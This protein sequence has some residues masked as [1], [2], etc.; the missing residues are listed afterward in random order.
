[1]TTEE[2]YTLADME[3][4]EQID[5]DLMEEHRLRMQKRIN[6]GI[7]ELTASVLAWADM[8]REIRTGFNCFF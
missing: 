4:P 1:M 6:A 3:Y 5:T 8:L 7:P 2:F